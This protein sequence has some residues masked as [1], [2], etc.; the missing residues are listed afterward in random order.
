M[1]IYSI[2]P[3]FQKLLL[4][5]T[6]IMIKFKIHPTLINFTALLVSLITGVLFLF[7]T[8]YHFLLL[9]IP[10]LLFIRIS[11]NALDGLVARELN[12]SSKKGEIFNEF[13]DRISDSIIFIGLTFYFIRDYKNIKLV[14]IITVEYQFILGFIFIILFLLNSY[15]GIL[16]KAAGKDRIYSGIIGK[17]DRMFYLGFASLIYFFYPDK[18]IWSIFYVFV[19]L[20]TI[21]SIGQRLCKA[22]K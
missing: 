9:V 5:V 2:K 17:A 19:I 11:F 7:I 21:I 1:T 22:V 14:S 6:K 4:P 8:K 13:F 20:G 12:I 16:A 18:I 15:L 3:L 10:V